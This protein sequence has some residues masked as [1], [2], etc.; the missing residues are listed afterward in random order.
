MAPMGAVNAKKRNVKQRQ[1]LIGLIVYILLDLIE[2]VVIY[3]SVY[4]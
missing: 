3:Y 4:R 2:Y 1:G